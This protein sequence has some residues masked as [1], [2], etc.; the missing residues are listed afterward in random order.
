MIWALWFF[1]LPGLAP[2]REY[3]KIIPPPMPVTAKPGTALEVTVDFEVLPGYHIN[4]NKP[5]DEYMIPT[6]MEWSRLAGMKHKGDFF[7]PAENKAFS[8]TSGRKLAVY[9]GPQI[10][11]SRFTVPS[12]AS[13]GRAVLEGRLR[14]Q[15]CDDKACYPPTAAEVKVTVEIKR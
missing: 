8:F 15:A 7:P 14:Y 1:L 3:V 13:P 2:P 11:K 5:T 6:R 4:S 12:T 10:L 9:E